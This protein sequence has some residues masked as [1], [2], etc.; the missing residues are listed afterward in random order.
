MAGPAPTASGVGQGS[1][2]T[3]DLGLVSGCHSNLGTDTRVSN[4]CDQARSSWSEPM[5]HWLHALFR[6]RTWQCW[7]GGA[8]SQTPCR[9]MPGLASVIP[10]S[11]PRKQPV[12]ARARHVIYLISADVQISAPIS[13]QHNSPSRPCSRSPP[14]GRRPGAAATL[15]PRHDRAS[16]PRTRAVRPRDTT[17]RPS[18]ELA[19]RSHTT[20]HP[21]VRDG[22]LGQVDSD[23]DAFDHTRSRYGP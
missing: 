3:L 6:S 5:S 10:Y 23:D 8:G 21:A 1:L 22:P 20:R 7:S 9:P 15:P 17:L 19:R 2:F 14:V 4:S 13:K 12:R 11:R 18:S 16:R